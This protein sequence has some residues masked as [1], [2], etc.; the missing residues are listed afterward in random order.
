MKKII[1]L[2]DHKHRDFSSIS[3]IGYFLEKK[4]HKVYFKKIHEP[5]VDIINPDVIVEAKYS[6]PKK[7]RKII[8]Q[9]QKKG[10]KIIVLETEGIVQWKGFKPLMN[11]KPDFCFFWNKNHGYEFDKNIY[12]NKTIILGCPRSDFL[13]KDFSELKP[14]INLI[15]ELKLNKDLKTIT[16]ATTNTYEDLSLEKLENIKKRYYEVHEVNT[17]FE[18]LIT[19]MK[20]S[21]KSITSFCEDFVKTD[22]QCNLIIKPHPNE[23]VFFW[24]NFVNHL[25]D[26]RIRILLGKTIQDLLSISDLHLAKTGCLTLPEASLSEIN[27]IELL[28]TSEISK[29]I[30]FDAH[31]YLGTY[32]VHKFSEIK[33]DLENLIN[34]QIPIEIKNKFQKKIDQY[35]KNYFYKH[36]GRRCLEYSKVLDNYLNDNNN[37]LNQKN[38][39]LRPI[40]FT[41]AIIKKTLKTMYRKFLKNNVSLLDSR[42]RFD[43]KIS[44]NDKFQ[45][46]SKYD[47]T[48]HIQDLIH[49]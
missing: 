25:N 26:K 19:H 22:I 10:I 29:Q 13:H 1:F 30:F 37:F 24:K 49:E 17:S 18:N 11:Y 8:D 36:D 48:K 21:R 16:I 14:E 40:N 44:D 3:L 47:Q 27:T 4:G 5:D 39:Y 33:N 23:N 46:F 43:S 32:N 15:D 31:T 38:N 35:I 41:L 7:Y 9:W 42:G 28:S 12:K 2:V 6:R 34:N 45:F 20:D